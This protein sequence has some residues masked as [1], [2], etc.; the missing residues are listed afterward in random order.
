MHYMIAKLARFQL[1]C[2]IDASV[3]CPCD[4]ADEQLNTQRQILVAPDIV[5]NIM[6]NDK[7]EWTVNGDFTFKVNMVKIAT[8][9]ILNMA[10]MV[11]ARG[12]L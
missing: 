6:G 5:T 10:S 1:V 7:T 12:D 9:N 2:K 8:M 4:F 3:K 11:T